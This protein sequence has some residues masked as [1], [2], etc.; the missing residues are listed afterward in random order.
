MLAGASGVC[1]LACVRACVRVCV[2][3]CMCVCVCVC[4]CLSVCVCV[5]VCSCVCLFQCVA[6]P[7][8]VRGCVLV[9]TS[10][11][12]APFQ[13]AIHV[14]AT[15]VHFW[16]TCRRTC[17]DNAPHLIAATTPQLLLLHL[18]SCVRNSALVHAFHVDMS[19]FMS[20]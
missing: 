1:V 20:S 10:T 4:V 11:V 18:P 3:A 8:R 14:S 17:W 5:S 12:L 16:C 9:Y 6:S 15:L 7:S 19:L 13:T 2:R